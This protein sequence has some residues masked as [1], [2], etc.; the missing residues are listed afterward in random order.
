MQIYSKLTFEI[1]YWSENK[2]VNGTTKTNDDGVLFL[3]NDVSLQK[4]KIGIYKSL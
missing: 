3:N 1:Y 2:Y 4:G